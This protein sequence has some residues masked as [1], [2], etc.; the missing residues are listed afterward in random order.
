MSTT[1]KPRIAEELLATAAR[2]GRCE[3]VAGELRTMSPAGYRHGLV[4]GRLHRR[5]ADHVD[6]RRLGA[7][8]AA[9]T[10]FLLRRDPDTVRAPDVGFVQ[11]A[12]HQAAGATS[13]F[14]PG[15]P[16]LAAEVLSPTDGP[17]D[18]AAKVGEWLASGCRMVLV[19]DP[20]ARTVAVH[21]PGGSVVCL[22]DDAVLDGADVVPGWRLHIAALFAA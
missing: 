12:R 7:V 21:R 15:A 22:R 2:W 5:L 13:A 1:Q 8:T 18:V 10:G 20:E 9:E 19:V 17:R 4:A 6:D 3:L 16:D 11:Q 14:F